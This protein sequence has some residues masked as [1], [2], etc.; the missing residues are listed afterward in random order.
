MQLPFDSAAA[1]AMSRNGM[2]TDYRFI[3][4]SAIL[5]AW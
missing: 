1:I 2:W 4:E 5:A 3:R